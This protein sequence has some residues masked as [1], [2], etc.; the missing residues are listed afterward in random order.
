MAAAQPCP[1]AVVAGAAV[2][3]SC[4]AVGEAHDDGH[5]VEVV[6]DD[7]TAYVEGV[8]VHVAAWDVDYKSQELLML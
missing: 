4:A 3:R 5:W 8:E 1:N 2:A 6:V 7:L